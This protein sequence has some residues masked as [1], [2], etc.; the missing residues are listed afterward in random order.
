[1]KRYLEFTSPSRVSLL[2]L[3][4]GTL[5]GCAVPVKEQPRAGFISDYS[6]LEQESDSAYVYASD[7]LGEYG[8]FLIDPIE[9]LIEQPSEEEERTFSEEELLSLKTFFEDQ[10]RTALTRDE[11]YEVVTEPGEGVARVRHG[12]TA[13]DASTGAL[14]ISIFTKI[15]GA[16]LG[17]AAMESEVVDS[18]T[19]QQVSAAVQWGNG[20]R[21]LA[22]G[23][24]KLGDAKGQIKRWVRDLRRRIDRAHGKDSGSRGAESS[25]GRG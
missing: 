24:T 6:A 9:I 12:V 17:G 1:M 15:T 4:V 25:A 16:G 2:V 11:G 5:A 20:S 14:N 10:L 13:L 22:A 3:V 19:G 21:V 23:I 8:R 18:L 7:K